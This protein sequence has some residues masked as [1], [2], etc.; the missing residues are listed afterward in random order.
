VIDGRTRGNL[1]ESHWIHVVIANIDVADDWKSL[2]AVD[3]LVALF[4]RTDL[5]FEVILEHF[6]RGRHP[7]CFK[8]CSERHLNI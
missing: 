6:P 7:I 1:V 2:E 5:A 8:R 3:G 4:G